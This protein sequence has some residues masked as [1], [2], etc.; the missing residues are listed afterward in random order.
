MK[1]STREILL[2]TIRRHGPVTLAGLRAIHPKMNNSTLKTNIYS[3]KRF[4]EIKDTE[5][6]MVYVRQ[7]QRVKGFFTVEPL[8]NAGWEYVPGGSL[9]HGRWIDPLDG[10]KHTTEDALAYQAWRDKM[11]SSRKDIGQANQNSP[12]ARRN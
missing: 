8:R 4:G 10:E 7:S 2:Q 12:S 11:L 9:Y 6:G 5:E 3:F 1:R